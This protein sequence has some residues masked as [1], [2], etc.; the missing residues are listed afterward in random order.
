MAIPP[1]AWWPGNKTDWGF[2][3]CGHLRRGYAQRRA[4]SR[5]DAGGRDRVVVEDRRQP[6]LAFRHTPA[7]ALGVILDLVALDLTDAEIMTLR[8]A[9]IEPGDC[10]ARPHGEA[11]GQLDA[12]ALAVEQFEQRALFS[13]IRLGGIAGRGT[14]AAIFFGNHLVAAKRLIARIAPEILANALV[15]TLRKSLGQPVGQRLDHDGGVIVIGALETVGDLVL[16]DAGGNR[17]GPD[18]I[19]QL[20][21]AR[22]HEIAERLVEAALAFG[23]LLTQRMKHSDGRAARLVGIDLDIV[24][25]AIGGT[26]AGHRARL[27]PALGDDLVQHGARVRSTKTRG[28]PEFGVVENGGVFAVQLPGLEERRPVDEIHQLGD[29]I[30]GQRL[31]ADEAWLWRHIGARPV[32]LERVAARLAKRQPGFFFLGARM[33]GRDLGVFAAQLSDVRRARIRRHQS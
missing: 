18:V 25:N 1:Q 10:R 17:E 29:R 9:E 11:L 27:E 12:D 21:V 14:D 26:E 31:G 24:A 6:A 2:K 28:R 19:G 33:S 22:R 13:V 4:S 8:V 7:L 15:Q 20:A 30:I 23:Q 5:H 3:T 32:E 16:T